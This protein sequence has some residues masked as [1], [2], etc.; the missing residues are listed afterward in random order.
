MLQKFCK[1]FYQKTFDLINDLKLTQKSPSRPAIFLDGNIL[2]L[3]RGYEELQ[4]MCVD[5]PSMKYRYGFY[6]YDDIKVKDKIYSY[7]KSIYTIIEF[8]KILNNSINIIQSTNLVFSTDKLFYG[9]LSISMNINNLALFD[10]VIS[11]TNISFT[12]FAT[13]LQINEFLK[14]LNSEY[15]YSLLEKI[16]I[17]ESKVKDLL[18]IMQNI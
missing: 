5:L 12:F 4:I 7:L 14:K 16:F 18:A 2:N 9:K 15:E 1:I 3:N 13:D 8:V 17:H 11:N 10:I 6:D